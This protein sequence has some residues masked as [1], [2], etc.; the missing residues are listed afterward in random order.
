MASAP[1]YILV[2]DDDDGVRELVA[3][4]ITKVGYRVDTAR[5]G[6]EAWSALCVAAY[7]LLITDNSMPK[8]SGLNLIRRLRAVSPEPPCILITGGPSIPELPS[9]GV[10]HHSAILAK[11]FS[12]EELIEMIYGVLLHGDESL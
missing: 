3:R 10:I 6:E 9:R 8:L 11:P 2:V 12:C 1:K 7:D 5:D 4:S